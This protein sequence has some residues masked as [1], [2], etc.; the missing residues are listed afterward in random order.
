MEIALTGKTQA[1]V[2]LERFLDPEDWN[3]SVDAVFREYAY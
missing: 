3:G 2:K 1:D